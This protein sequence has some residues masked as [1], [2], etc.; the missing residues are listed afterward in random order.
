MTTD[1][2]RDAFEQM[3][4]DQLL[5]TAA[6]FADEYTSEGL[7]VLK[8]VADS[9]GI[10]ETTIRALRDSCYPEIEFAFKCET[11]DREILL[12]REGFVD[13]EYTCPD[14]NSCSHV[15]YMELALPA[16]VLE[17]FS[18]I[19]LAGGVLG[20]LR[21]SRKR[22]ARREGIMDGSYWNKL[23]DMGKSSHHDNR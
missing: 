18:R 7:K 23:K 22:A 9:H 6:F 11:C 14:C 5:T 1:P 10:T 21:D 3:D 12:N 16:S 8:A 13:G 17:K 4:D 20:E 15:R 19:M 2:V